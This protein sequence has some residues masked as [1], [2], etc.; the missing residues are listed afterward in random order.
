MEGTCPLGVLVPEQRLVQEP[1][2]FW[3]FSLRHESHL[4]VGLPEH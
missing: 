1:I 4:I 2:R 3:R